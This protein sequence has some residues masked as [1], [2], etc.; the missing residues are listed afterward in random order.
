MDRN[1]LNRT[2]SGMSDD[3]GVKII[4]NVTDY[5]TAYQAAKDAWTGP[6]DWD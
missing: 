1:T 5:L 3:N 2:D 6:N 4:A